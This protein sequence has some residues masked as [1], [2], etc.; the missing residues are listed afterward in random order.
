MLL[1]LTNQVLRIQH[2]WKKRCHYI[3]ARQGV[4]VHNSYNVL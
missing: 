4:D 2:V 3:F 1:K